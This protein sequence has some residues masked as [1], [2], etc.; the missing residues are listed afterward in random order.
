MV[1]TAGGLRVVTRF[2]SHANG[3]FGQPGY[4]GH[5]LLAPQPVSPGAF[6]IGTPQSVQV[7]AGEFTN[8]TIHYD[9]GIR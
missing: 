7:E 1:K 3:E 8:A 2:T 9:T 5:E 6:P 4:P